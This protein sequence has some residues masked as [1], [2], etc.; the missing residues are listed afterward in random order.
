MTILYSY[1]FFVIYTISIDFSTDGRGMGH[2]CGK[3]NVHTGFWWGNLS[4][5]CHLEHLGA[6]GRIILKWVLNP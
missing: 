3:E 4:A 6:D 2:V 1:T 5:K